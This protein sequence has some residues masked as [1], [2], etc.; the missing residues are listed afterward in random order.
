MIPGENLD[1]HNEG[2][3][4]LINMKMNVNVSFSYFKCIKNTQCLYIT[5][6][7]CRCIKNVEVKCMTKYYK[8]Q[9]GNTILSFLYCV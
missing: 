2:D 3:N 6:V 4:R 9:E 1:L 5:I 7:H 8:E